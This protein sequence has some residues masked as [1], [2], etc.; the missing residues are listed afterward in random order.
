MSTYTDSEILF[1]LLNNLEQMQRSNKINLWLRQSQDAKASLENVALGLAKLP[2]S[3]NAQLAGAVYC[4][5]QALMWSKYRNL[6]VWGTIVE[7]R[8]KEHDAYL[9]EMW[10]NEAWANLE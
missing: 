9:R 8:R 2:S 10:A 4:I 3:K 7:Y 5:G 6:G 1:D